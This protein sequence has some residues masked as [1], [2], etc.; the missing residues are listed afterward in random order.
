MRVLSS[1]N[2]SLIYR[3]EN[4]SLDAKN[5]SLMQAEEVV[6]LAPKAA[7]LLTVLV[8][9]AGEIVDK[10]FLLKTLWNETFVEDANLTQNIYLLR[11][12]LGKTADGKNYI[13]TFPKRGYKF[14]PVVEI[15][16]TD[17]IVETDELFTLKDSPENT[18][19]LEENASGKCAPIQ[20]SPKSVYFS[21]FS[22]YK[23]ALIVAFALIAGIVIYGLNASA[24]K[25][26]AVITEAKT[27]AVMPFKIIGADNDESLA[28]GMTDA[29]IT[30]LGKIDK[31]QILP[32]EAVRRYQNPNKDALTAGRELNVE[33]ILTGNIQRADNRLRVTVQ[34]LRVADESVLWT[35]QFDENFTD[36]F[37]VQDVIS[38]KLAGTLALQLSDDERRKLTAKYTD[39]L[40]AYETYLKCRY[41]WGKR[42]PKEVQKS[43]PCFEDAIRLDPKFALAYA[44]LADAY[45][46]SNSG[47]PFR[48]RFPK[49][50]AAAKQAL[51]L[52]ETLAEAHTSLAFLLYKADWNWA[53]SEKHFRRAIELNP[54]YALAHH[55]FGEFLGLR[56][57]FDE[58]IAELNKASALD[59]LSLS[60]KS[61]LGRIYYRAR[62]Y[63]EAINLSRKTLELDPNFFNAWNTLTLAYEQKHLNDESISANLHSLKIGNMPS[64]QLEKLAEAYASG[65]WTAYWRERRSLVLKNS[66]ASQNLSYGF[67]EISLRAGEKQT[68]LKYLAESV[69]L[70]D[71]GALFFVTD[72]LLDPLRSMP[73]FEE[74]LQKSN[75]SADE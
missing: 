56:G 51:A 55:W 10:D 5:Q 50:K 53:E 31:I 58:G 68:A 57:R 17:E 63:D 36:I 45:A 43:I 29:I 28:I 12:V 54:N 18:L 34:L 1:K 30:R 26:S 38:Q 13:Q 21:V 69:K 74:L 15:I 71:D 60:I 66:S 14:L 70:H 73:E 59:P 64:D 33:T 23:I 20:L 61:D 19:F 11:K 75:N 6:L 16:Q 24:K 67:A 22:Q 39:N 8:E 27:L 52:D 32:T 2:K 40:E 65:G 48:E 37:S 7:E 49:A 4:F 41:Y 25:S 47:L 46:I 44:G 35:D 62:N 3:F 9:R 42:T 72:P